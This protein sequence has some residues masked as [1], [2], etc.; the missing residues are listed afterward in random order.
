MVE[1]AAI[2]DLRNVSFTYASRSAPSLSGVNLTIRRGD[3]VLLT[4][5]I[6]CGKSTLLKALNG[7]IPQESGGLLTGKIVVDG[8][9]A[10]AVSV[11]ELSSL[12]GMMFQSPDDQIFSTTLADEVAFI[13]ENMGMSSREIK[14]RVSET[15][16]LVGLSGMEGCSVHSLSGGQK[17]R[18]A[19]AAVLAGRPPILALDEP[20]SQLDPQGASAL[21]A[22]VE[23][24][25]KALGITVVIVEHRLHEVMPLCRHAVIMDE[26]RI[27]WSGTRAEAFRRPD[28]F[29][30]YG[31][32]L[33]QTVDICRQLDIATA[34]ADIESAVQLIQDRYDMRE[35]STNGHTPRCT[36]KPAGICETVVEAHDVVFRYEE[37]GR[38]ILDEMSLTVYKGQFVAVMGNNGAGKSTLLQHIAGL[39]T[40]EAGRVTVLGRAAAKAKQT[41]GMVLQ[42]PDFMLFN[43]TVADEIDF[44]VKQQRHAY[45]KMEHRRRELINCLGLNGMEED[46]PLALSRGQR[47]RVAIA[48]V[49]SYQPQVLLLDEPTTG[50][51]IGHIDDIIALLKQYTE[52][53][54]TVLFCTHDTEI[55]AQYADRVIVM[56][57]GRIVAAGA[58]RSVFQQEDMLKLAGLRPPA[59]MLVARRLYGG[60]AVTVKE[61][62]AYVRKNSMGGNAGSHPDTPAGRQ[63]E[64]DRIGVGSCS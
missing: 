27:V 55:V 31:L 8:H 14:N 48:A 50:Q 11:A 62:V 57:Q 36:D 41:V 9:D 25:N 47:L 21:L 5:A 29:R 7:L 6:G 60:Q 53:G 42:N 18:L 61:V 46:F 40:P 43:P 45:A 3:F 59:A 39:L 32:R 51:D 54:G 19:L 23:R 2:I 56:T 33:P 34:T 26:G 20:I 52:Q 37:K 24:L 22:V 1:N 58:P 13:L 64:I 10:G 15:L 28:L 12:V 38:N 4:G 17:Q 49:L 44:A 16:A 63:D 30:A 35:P